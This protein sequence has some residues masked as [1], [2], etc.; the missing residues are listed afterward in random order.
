MRDR[1]WTILGVLIGIFL[2]QL[3]LIPRP[4]LAA[5]LKPVTFSPSLQRGCSV[6]D[7][8]TPSSYES[9]AKLLER[10]FKQNSH[11]GSCLSFAGYQIAQYLEFQQGGAHSVLPDSIPADC[12]DSFRRDNQ[13]TFALLQRI[14]RQDLGCHT[15][16]AGSTQSAHPVTANC[17]RFKDAMGKNL[18]NGFDSLEACEAPQSSPAPM[19]SHR[20]LTPFNIQYLESTSSQKNLERIREH[21]SKPAPPLLVPVP[22]AFSFC[23]QER[24]PNKPCTSRD[25]VLITGV[26]NACCKNKC[27]EEWQISAADSNRPTGWYA[28]SPLSSSSGEYHG[29][30]T[31]VIPCQTSGSGLQQCNDTVL[32]NYP[33]HYLAKTGDYTT[34]K[35]H[36]P[37]LAKLV[38][39]FDNTDWTPLALASMGGSGDHVRTV[40]LLLSNKADPNLEDASSMTPLHWALLNRSAVAPQIVGLMLQKGAVF[41]NRDGNFS[42]KIRDL[43]GK[44]NPANREL[45]EKKRKEYFLNLHKNHVPD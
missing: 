36:L 35:N 8:R 40:Q 19:G 42:G 33:L 39:Q 14:R 37:A 24:D 25:T 3:A 38:N 11:L 5:P 30:M 23:A 43:A 41:L 4:T 29:G 45:L 16:V 31:R 9:D 21:F 13:S 34:L 1:F 10:V 22:V 6:K 32:G 7:F 44:G 27:Q 18:K 26:R 2:G 17:T 20:K 12:C 28:A 15:T